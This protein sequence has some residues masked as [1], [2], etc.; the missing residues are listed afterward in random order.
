MSIK[1]IIKKMVPQTVINCFH[2]VVCRIRARN[3]ALVIEYTDC[4][5]L[6]CI[7]NDKDDFV[8]GYY[9]ISP[10]SADGTKYLM[11]RLHNECSADIILYDLET[12]T[13]K[14][15]N[16]TNAVN[17][18]QGSRIRWLEDSNEFYYY[19]DCIDGAYVCVRASVY[20]Q[21]G[22]IVG[23]AFYDLSDS[24]N[25]GMALNFSRLG[26]MRAGYGYRTLPYE[27]QTEKELLNEGIDI[28]DLKSGKSSRPIQYEDLIKKANWKEENIERYYINHISC[29]PDGKK[30]IFF[31]VD[32]M[33]SDS[34]LKVALF[35]YNIENDEIKLL[36]K[37]NR[38]S[39]YAWKNNDEILVTL[40]DNNMKCMYTIINV[41]TGDKK[42]IAKDSLAVDGHPSWID[43][44]YFITD[45]YPNRMGYQTLYCVNAEDD[46]KCML[47]EMYH[48]C[49]RIGEMR[50]DMHPRMN[51]EKNC[52][53][54][55]GNIHGKRNVYIMDFK[56]ES[57]GCDVE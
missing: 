47:V 37:D 27:K 53:G 31:F 10:F 24:L 1:K 14:T 40:F 56:K 52:I 36:E 19:N 21:G 26:V 35:V 7:T 23:P 20:K 13:Q 57:I 8:G 33:D 51:K 34:N 43:D 17:R 42:H 46:S 9:D 5:S 3:K 16:S 30:F 41:K 49:R 11:L 50:C 4:K 45:T 18:Q 2:E 28:W 29:A 22:E 32:K 38:T 55:D 25:Y 39:H 6:R 48:T 15:I 12:S 44:K 54:F